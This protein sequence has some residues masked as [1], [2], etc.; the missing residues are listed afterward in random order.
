MSG[1]WKHYQLCSKVSTHM[2]FS[3][4]CVSIACLRQ[5]TIFD[6]NDATKT[7]VVIKLDYVFKMCLIQLGG[8]MC[9]P[10]IFATSFLSSITF[11][12]HL[13]FWNDKFPLFKFVTRPNDYKSIKWSKLC[14]GTCKCVHNR[15]TYLEACSPILFRW[16]ENHTC[17]STFD[18]CIYNLWSG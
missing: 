5:R 1:T 17:L 15:A 9:S 2:L 14:V 12:H 8:F 3:L 7:Y 11:A 16:R 13:R 10:I 4:L 18:W 6:R